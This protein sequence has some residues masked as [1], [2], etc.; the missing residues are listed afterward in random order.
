MKYKLAMAMLNHRGEQMK[1]GDVALTLGMVLERA[2]MFG[3][4]QDAKASEKYQQFK[5]AQRIARASDLLADPID[6]TAEEVTRLKKLCAQVYTPIAYGAVVDM[7]EQP[8]SDTE[9]PA[10]VAAVI[11]EF[12]APPPSE[13]TTEP[14]PAE[15]IGE[16]GV[17]LPAK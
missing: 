5:F 8:L 4:E 11:G 6:F 17:L 10:K 7:L 15:L 14:T 3:G 9:L 13:R 2:C 16:P 1:E 12:A